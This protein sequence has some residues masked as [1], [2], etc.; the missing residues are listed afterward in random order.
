MDHD[1]VPFDVTGPASHKIADIREA[2]AKITRRGL[3]AMGEKIEY[4]PAYRSNETGHFAWDVS[5]LIRAACL[6]WRVTGD[7]AHLRQAVTWAQHVVERTDE[8]L[9]LTNW[10]GE[11][12]PVWSAGSRYTAGT[13]TVGAF[14]GASIRLQ[15][16]AD[17]VI[18]ERPSEAT[19]IVRAVRVNGRSWSSPESSLLPE[20]ENYLPDVLAQL[21]ASFAVLLRGMPEPI[22]LRSLAAGR[23]PLGPQFAAHLVHTGTIARSL[24]CAAEVLELAGPEAIDSTITPAELLTA[25]ERALLF[26]DREIRIRSGHAWYITPRC[27]PGRRLGLELP[28]NH[29]V[30]AATAYMIL[31]RRQGDTALHNLGASLTRRFLGEI[32]A[33]EFGSLPH[34][35]FYYPV[36]SEIFYGVTRDEPIAERRILA[37][38]RGED[39]SHA[40]MRVRA[41]TE[42]KRISDEL[43]PDEVLSSVALSFRRHFMTSVKR[44]ATLRWLPGDQEDS[45]QLGRADT[46]PGAWGAL[47]P[48]DSTL[49]RRINSM[50]YRHPPTAAFGATVLSS[51]EILA[52]NAGV[53]TYASSDRNA[54][55]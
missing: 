13:A 10:R 33:Y 27:F 53:P 19:A 14:G 42:W 29:V 37:V 39:S 49:K 1:S 2:Y 35:W 34:P 11:S 32:E 38:P 30:D 23:F 26:H 47:V 24:I 18:I 20:S 41:L 36:D 12:G 31:G 50:A 4:D 52:M 17:R 15:A 9:G 21:S 6:T 7:S 28:H 5:L 45:P 48:W 16:V 25:A 44:V 8:K 46:Y 22:D 43:V 51:A 40:T 54:R 3:E 55:A